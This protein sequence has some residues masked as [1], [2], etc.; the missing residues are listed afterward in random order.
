VGIERAV[1][2]GIDL[3]IEF[4]EGHAR[5]DFGICFSR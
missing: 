2:D 1:L 3:D 5:M 4:D